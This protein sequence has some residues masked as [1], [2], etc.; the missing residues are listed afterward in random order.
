MASL[1]ERGLLIETVY[2]DY[3]DDDHDDDILVRF[4]PILVNFSRAKKAC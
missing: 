1:G 4:I 3:D 2:G